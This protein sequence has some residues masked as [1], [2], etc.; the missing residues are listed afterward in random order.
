MMAENTTS[1]PHLKV[2]ISSS[3]STCDACGDALARGAWIVSL[4]H[5]RVLCLTCAD[6]DHL[7]F[8]PP[9]NAALTRRSRKHSTLSA[10]V[11]KW[12]RARKR[13]ERQGILVESAALEQAESECLADEDIRMR[14]RDRE[15]ERRAHEDHQYIQRFAARVRDLYPKCPAGREMDIAEHACLK[16]SGRVGRT[17]AAKNLEAET[18]RMAV[19]AHV[20]HTETDYDELLAQTGDRRTARAEVDESIRRTL[21]AWDGTG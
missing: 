21:R 1:H 9:G 5:R 6:L 10:I 7:D 3:E 12:S 2:F 16:Y 19:I 4:E 15:A 18:I 11:L 17:V 14:R 13:F 20:R 8:L